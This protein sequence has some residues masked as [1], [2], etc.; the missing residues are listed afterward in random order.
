MVNF[1]NKGQGPSSLTDF[2][3]DRILGK[4]AFGAVYKVTNQKTGIS[5]AMK[6]IKKGDVIRTN[7]VKSLELEKDI[8]LQ[9][10]HPFV[11]SMKYIFQNSVHVFFVLDYV[12][13]GDLFRHMVTHR[14]FDEEMVRFMVAQVALALE[15]MHNMGIIYRDLKPENILFNSDGYLKVA[16]FGLSR[17]FEA[18]EV[19]KTNVG[20]PSYMAPEMLRKSGHNHTVDIWCLG[21]LMFELLIGIPPF[22]SRDQQLMFRNIVNKT[23]AFPQ[24]I[25]LHEDTMDL[26]TK[27]LDKNIQTRIGAKQGMSEI[28]SHPYF[29][30][31][32]FKDLLQKKIEPP[33]KPE[34]IDGDTKYLD[35]K[36]E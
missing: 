15:H 26:I 3:I 7:G 2:K 32:D 28:L 8:L 21:T 18:G 25:P 23:L 27:M 34:I 16:D 17:K 4:G 14:R 22:Y 31:I 29:A 1:T 11:V 20:T 9:I 35:P 10:D 13:G 12:Q 5:Y 36:L 19:Y 33:Y 30:T 24:K 6:C